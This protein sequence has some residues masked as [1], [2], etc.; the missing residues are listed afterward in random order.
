MNTAFNGQFPYPRDL[1]KNTDNPR[2]LTITNYAPFPPYYR[3]NLQQKAYKARDLLNATVAAFYRR[4]KDLSGRQRHA[5][6]A[7]TSRFT[8]RQETYGRKP[9]PETTNALASAGDDVRYLARQLDDFFFFRQV[10]DHVHIKTGFDVVGRDP[11]RIDRRVEGETFRRAERN[12]SFVQIVINVGSHSDDRLYP[13]DA[14]VGQLMHEMVHAYLLVFACDCWR[15]GR[16]SLNTVGVEDDGH[17][18]AFLMLHRLVLSEMRK[19]DASLKGLLA[20]D[21]P[22]A[23]VSRSALGRAVAAARSLD[24]RERQALNPVRSHTFA[25]YLVRFSASGTSVLVNPTLLA[26][27]LEK[28][29]ALKSKKRV[30]KLREEWHVEAEEE[31]G[32]YDESDASSGKHSSASG[33]TGSD[34]DDRSS[35]YAS[36]V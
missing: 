22:G 14:I 25:N 15:C 1:K 2:H 33:R 27:Q 32:G 28:E 5:H 23:S 19:W 4:D 7:F 10:I 21:C 8:D 34:E 29:G 24:D 31:E 35:S 36:D 20:D 30:Q 18:P 12:R 17:G 6:E 3:L 16:D 13:L 11:L 9:S 26:R